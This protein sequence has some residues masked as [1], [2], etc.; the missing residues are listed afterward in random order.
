VRTLSLLAGALLGCGDKDAADTADHTANYLIEGNAAV[1]VTTQTVSIDEDCEMSL[2]LYTPAEH[3]GG[4]LLILAHGFVRSQ[5]NMAGWASHLASWGV[6]VTTPDLCHSSFTDAD[7]AANADELRALNDAIGAGPVIY[8][9]QSAGGLSALIAAAEDDDALA[10]IG[11][12]ATDSDGLGV[13]RVSGAAVPL[14]GLVGEPSD[15][16]ADSNGIAIYSAAAQ[17]TAF[18]VVESDHC[19]FEDE[20]DVLCTAL[21]QGDNTQFSEEEIHEVILGML[22]SAVVDLAGA[23]SG[24]AEW[25]T[26][27]GTTHD[28]L[29]ESGAILP[30]AP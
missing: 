1:T 29:I 3:S 24:R 20:T 5:I 19:D 18:R 15:C 9:G 23:G 7:H 17:A 22:T 4:P 6:Q 27:G 16:N 28:A 2:S 8:A 10:G 26:P 14:L 21:C 30:L 11:L 12:D 25:W 13:E